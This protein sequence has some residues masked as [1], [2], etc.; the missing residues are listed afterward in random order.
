MF[1]PRRSRSRPVLRRLRVLFL[2]VP[3]QALGLLL[4]AVVLGSAL[5]SVPL[6]PGAAE[7]GVWERERAR[8][9]GS[10]VGATLSSSTQPLAQASSRAR[11]A[12]A[13][14]L[15]AAVVETARAEG[16]GTPVS[17]VRLRNS[18]FT[19]VPDGVVRTQ[20]MAKIGWEEQV[21]IVTQG[22]SRESPDGVAGQE[23]VLVGLTTMP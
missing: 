19:D 15:D 10:A 1:R 22:C 12:R 13:S 8:Q 3:S 23:A 17:V 2:P 18:L 16:L 4:L 11:I 21:E 20:L 14:A 7:Q 5:V 9:E 6:V